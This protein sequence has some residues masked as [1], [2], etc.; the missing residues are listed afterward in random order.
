MQNTSKKKTHLASL[1]HLIH[2]HQDK[3][4]L[5]LAVE[6]AA[7]PLSPVEGRHHVQYPAGLDL[8]GCL[9]LTLLPRTGERRFSAFG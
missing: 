9:S 1:S 7:E 6:G 8:L 2:H 4:Q 5:V 3:V